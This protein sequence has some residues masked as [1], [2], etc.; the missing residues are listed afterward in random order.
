[1]EQYDA[2][3][4]WSRN[5]RQ[6]LNYLWGGGCNRRFVER[7]GAGAAQRAGWHCPAAY[8][9]AGQAQGDFAL[10]RICLTHHRPAGDRQNSTNLYMEYI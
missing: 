7:P 6:P 1:M 8:V 4:H 5:E 2:N 9:A 10:V 3:S